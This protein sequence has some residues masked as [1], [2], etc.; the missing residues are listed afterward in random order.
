[1]SPA[2]SVQLPLGSLMPVNMPSSLP[3]GYEYT[4]TP[5]SVASETYNNLLCCCAS[6]SIHDGRTP[7][8]AVVADPADSNE[9]GNGNDG[10]V[11]LHP[12]IIAVVM[13]ANNIF[14]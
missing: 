12:A 1:M 7:R 5:S 8:A 2:A 13:K 3:F 14:R 6:R 9:R 4:A 11:S 10:G